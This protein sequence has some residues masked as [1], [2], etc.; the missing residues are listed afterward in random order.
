VSAGAD[1]REWAETVRS[2]AGR[3]GARYEPVGGLN[4][5]DAPPALC[6]GGTNRVTGELING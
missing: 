5:R 1:A 6:P 3:R 2:L 4:P